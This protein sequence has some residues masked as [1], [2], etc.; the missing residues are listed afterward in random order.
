M[1]KSLCNRTLPH[2]VRFWVV[3]IDTVIY[4][5]SINIDIQIWTANV[6][7]FGNVLLTANEQEQVQSRVLYT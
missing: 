1:Q 6:F 2:S 7:H 4:I 5:T 3:N